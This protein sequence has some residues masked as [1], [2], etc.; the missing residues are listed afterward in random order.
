[1][2][3]AEI[4]EREGEFVIHSISR[5]TPGPIDVI[6]RV[7]AAGLAPGVFS[8][9]RS[10]SVP[11]LPTILGHEIAG[12]VDEVGALVSP[13]LIGSR[14]RIHP[15]LSCGK[16]EYCTSDREMM[17]AE[18]SMIGHSTFGPNA[19][20]RYTL[21]HDGGLA[22]FVKVPAANVDP[23]PSNVS[24]EL[25]AKVHDFANA[26][27]A[28]K[29][30]QLEPASTL[31][32]GAATGAMGVAT[33]ALARAF[34]VAR[35][36]AVGRDAVRLESVRQLDPDLISAVQLSDGGSAE[37]FVD[38]VRLIDPHGAHAAIDFFPSGP[39]TS[40][41]IGG[42]RFG[43][44]LVHMGMNR[45]PLEVPPAA[46]S[47]KC[48]TFVGTRNGTRK[49]ASDAIQ[50]LALDPSRYESL[51]THRFPLERANEVRDLLLNRTEP[52]WMSVITVALTPE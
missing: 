24:F 39:G 26:I 2:L 17:C 21:Y 50:I 22:E 10:G 34:G 28:L 52:M 18:N 46:L 15:N 47:F 33:I 36:I 49:D 25:G 12:T 14:V 30:A 35:V 37:E 4:F 44:R 51:I 40:I 41:V 42:L 19:L 5:P 8:R 23:L 20:E 1:M 9:L 45:E 38:N 48:I 13:D 31:I 43:G 32:V 29:L 6:V 27:R 11:I 3:A 7:H 16:C